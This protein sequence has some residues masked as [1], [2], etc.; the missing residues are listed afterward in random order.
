MFDTKNRHY[1]RRFEQILIDWQSALQTP[2]RRYTDTV[3]KRRL[4]D[5]FHEPGPSQAS[6]RDAALFS[7][8]SVGFKPTATVNASLCEAGAA[9]PLRLKIEMPRC[10]PKRTVDGTIPAVY[11]LRNAH[12]SHVVLTKT[13]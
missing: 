5:R 10:A 9:V 12:T 2:S 7:H 11:V 4:K 8:L 1:L 6:L 3:A 13:L